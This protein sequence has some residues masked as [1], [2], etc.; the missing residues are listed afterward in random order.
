MVCAPQCKTC[1]TTNFTCTSCNDMGTPTKPVF[2]YLFANSCVERCPYLNF[3][4]NF[5]NRS[6]DKCKPE[7]K[8]CVRAIDDCIV[9]NEGSVIAGRQCL[10]SCPE[11]SYITIIGT[12]FG[13]DPSCQKCYG[14]M[15]SMCTQCTTG[16]YLTDTT[17]ENRCNP[18]L[19]PDST[20][21]TCKQCQYYCN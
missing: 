14:A 3:Y 10:N 5:D 8:I 4:Q 9:C 20:T 17:C 2:M 6:C 18:P 12:C 11:K 19:Y 13:C 1:K 15:N 7:C 21:G 16:N